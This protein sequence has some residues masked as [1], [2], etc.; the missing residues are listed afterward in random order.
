MQSAFAPIYDLDPLAEGAPRRQYGVALL[1][2]HPIVAV[3]NHDLTRLSTQVPD[4]VPAPA[5]GFLEATVQI[6]G[7]RTHVYVTHLD[8]RGDPTV[9]ALQ[10]RD[11]LR[12]LGEDPEGANQVLLGDFNA[13]PRAPELQPL[14]GALQDA[15]AVAPE[16]AGAL[17]LTYPATA[18]TKRIDFVTAS[19]NTT[20]LRA[21]TQDDPTH[22]LA[23]DHRAVVATVLLNQGSESSR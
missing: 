22:I 23:S 21:Q 5:P 1:S 6:R 2:R 19:P 4:P 7:A 9:R 3:E 15:W 14:W 13:G 20:V 16:R 12:I 11:T 10:V 17:G 8:Y 18:P